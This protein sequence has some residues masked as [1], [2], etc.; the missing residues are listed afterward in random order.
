MVY[1]KKEKSEE[2]FHPETRYV[3]LTRSDVPMSMPGAL[4]QKGKGREVD[5]S[6]EDLVG[7]T[8]FRFDTE[9]TL[10]DKDVEVIYW[11]VSL[12]ITKQ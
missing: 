2:L 11:S 1:T 6:K 12:I 9:E 3:L 10:G 7:F 8:S 4:P 5:I